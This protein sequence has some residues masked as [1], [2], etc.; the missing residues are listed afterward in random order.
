M[1]VAGH[2]I[3][4]L[5][6]VSDRR[7]GNRQEGDR[8]VLFSAKTMPITDSSHLAGLWRASIGSGQRRNRFEEDGLLQGL[9]AQLVKT[10]LLALWV[11]RSP[12][13]G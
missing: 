2:P 12:S 13:T 10:I 11:R 8:D 9:R 5:R 1:S 4:R 7:G 6:V 3:E